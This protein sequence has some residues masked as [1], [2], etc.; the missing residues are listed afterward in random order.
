MRPS[1]YNWLGL[2]LACTF[3]NVVVNPRFESSIAFE[4]SVAFAGFVFW[5]NPS[6]KLEVTKKEFEKLEDDLKSLREQL[7]NLKVKIGFQRTA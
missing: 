1:L 7:T 3:C 6:R 2:L 5:L 4:F